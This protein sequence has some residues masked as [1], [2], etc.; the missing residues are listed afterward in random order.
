MP[1]NLNEATCKITVNPVVHVIKVSLNKTTDILTVGAKDTLKVTIAPTNATNKAVKW[2][3]SNT[4][5]A[6]VDIWGKVTSLKAGTTTITGIT[7]DGSKTVKC[8]LTVTNANIKGID[9]VVL[10]GQWINPPGG[11]PGAGIQGK[12][13]IQRILKKEKRS[14]KI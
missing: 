3:S 1:V 6:T 14:I 2:T 8:I 13:S 12:F 4:T 5:K 11:L 7:V 9:N 10:A